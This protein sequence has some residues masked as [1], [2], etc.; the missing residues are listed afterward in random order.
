M[1]RAYWGL[2]ILFIWGFSLFFFT[3]ITKGMFKAL[4]L[5]ASKQCPPLHAHSN[6]TQSTMPRALPPNRAQFPLQFSVHVTFDC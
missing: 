4:G 3:K 6:A 1:E 5:S 2:Q